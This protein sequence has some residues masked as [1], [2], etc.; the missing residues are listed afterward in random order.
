MKHKI[1][2]WTKGYICNTCRVWNKLKREFK[3]LPECKPFVYVADKSRSVYYI[4]L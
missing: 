4:D 3:L 1:E 2:K